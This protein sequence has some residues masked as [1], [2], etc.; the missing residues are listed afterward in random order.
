MAILEKSTLVCLIASVLF[1]VFLAS[2]LGG[3]PDRLFELITAFVG[4]LALAP[5][6]KYFLLVP[7]P[8][9]G[10]ISRR[11]GRVRYSFCR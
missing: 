1:T 4:P 7:L 6:F 2:G 5:V 8:S 3:E 9:E 11:M 10:G